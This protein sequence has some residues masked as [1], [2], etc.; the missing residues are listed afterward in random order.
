MRRAIAIEMRK[1]GG[2]KSF[3]GFALLSHFLQKFLDLDGGH[4]ACSGGG[5][6]LPITTVGNVSAGVN[7]GNRGKHI[8]AR[9]EIA[10]R[11][12]FK[13]AVKHCRIG[14]VADAQKQRAGRKVADLAWS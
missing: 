8:I 7:A 14:Y 6:G 10:V 13:L 9:F 1:D 11:V 5:N 3:V 4:A 12:G 2:S